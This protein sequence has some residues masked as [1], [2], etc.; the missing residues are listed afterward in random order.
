MAGDRRAH[1]TGFIDRG[2]TPD[3]IAEGFIES[4]DI[5]RSVVENFT[6]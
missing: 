4:I 2:V 1:F 3:V 6:P 5:F